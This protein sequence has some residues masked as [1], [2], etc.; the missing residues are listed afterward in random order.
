[1]ALGFRTRTEPKLSGGREEE[2]K[3]R[4]KT[5][6]KIKLELFSILGDGFIHSFIHSFMDDRWWWLIT[7]SFVFFRG[8]PKRTR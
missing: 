4:K 2:E 1:M 8:W 5:E 7:V 3:R 6:E